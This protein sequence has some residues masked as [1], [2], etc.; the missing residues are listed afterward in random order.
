MR[1]SPCREFEDTCSWSPDLAQMGLQALGCTVKAATKC[2]GKAAIL[3]F[4][5]CAVLKAIKECITSD[6]Y[7][8]N[9]CRSG[10][11]SNGGSNSGG[12][13]CFPGSAL[14]H[15]ADGGVRPMSSLVI[16][17]EVLGVG[18]DGQTEYAQVRACRPRS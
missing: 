7:D 9:N 5:K 12:S 15:T 1:R 11:S 14:V 8:K 2:P 4:G 17:D 16:G 18:P 6:C 10:G 3:C 13:F